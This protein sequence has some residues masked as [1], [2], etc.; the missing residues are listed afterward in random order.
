[1]KAYDNALTDDEIISIMGRAIPPEWP[2]KLL[3]LGK[4][5]WRFGDLNYQLATYRQQWQS[6]QQN[7]IMIK[8]A[9][10]LP[11]NSSDGKCKKN[12][13]KNHNSGGGCSGGRQG[14]NVRGGRRRGQ[15]GRNNDN[16]DHLKS[17]V[18]YNYDKKGH[19]STD[20]RARPR[21]MR[22]EETKMVSKAVCKNLYQSSLKE[23]I[24]K[25]GKQK[26]DKSNMELNDKSLDMDVFDKVMEGKQHKILIKMMMDQ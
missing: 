9:G 15:G 3:A 19:Y 2:G 26:N 21:K 14:N 22:N 24:Y 4:E 7:Q 5:P 17:F 1:V 18:C 12:E 6:D 8:I 23:M 13:R 10:K 25:K 16:N 20:C 11:G